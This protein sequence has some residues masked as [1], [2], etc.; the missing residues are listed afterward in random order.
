MHIFSCF[1]FTGI[2]VTPHFVANIGAVWLGD[3]SLS[4][5]V[6]RQISKVYGRANIYLLGIVNFIKK[7]DIVSACFQSNI[8]GWGD[9]TLKI[10]PGRDTFLSCAADVIINMNLW[11]ANLPY[12]NGVETAIFW[13]HCINSMVSRWQFNPFHRGRILPSHWPENKFVHSGHE[14]ASCMS[15]RN[16]FYPPCNKCTSIPTLQW[17]HNGRDGV[18]NHQPHDCLLNRIFRLR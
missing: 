10:F 2:A 11:D 4:V 5:T 17:R 18:S 8:C 9:I 12:S 16:V 7:I 3:F 1:A 13:E 6:L 14:P 15:C